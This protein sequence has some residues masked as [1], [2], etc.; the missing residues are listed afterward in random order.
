MVTQKMEAQPK[1]AVIILNYNSK[2]FIL[3]FLDNVVRKSLNADI[4]IFDN[5]S[6]DDSIEYIESKY[7]GLKIIKNKK[8]DGYAGGYNKALKEVCSD[9]YILLNSDIE[10]TDNWINPVIELMKKDNQIAACQPK[11]KNYYNKDYFEYAGASGGFLD[12]LGYPFCRGRIF[13]TVEKDYG[14]YNNSSEI[15]W[16]SGA[17]LFIKSKYFHEVNGFDIDFFAHME[18]ID[19]CWRLKNKGYSIWVEPASTVYHVGG[20]TLNKTNAFK[21]F[22]N[23]RNNLFMMFKN[24]KNPWKIIIIRLFLDGLAGLKFLVEGKPKHTLAIIKAH[25][26][27]YSNIKKLNNKKL[28]NFSNIK[29]FNKSVIISYYLKRIKKFSA[30]K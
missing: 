8:N 25:F 9:Y 21:T 12:Y 24:L 13:N 1:I 28:K 5:G 7:P 6:T 22:L 16:A 11:I 18:E 20:G 2:K 10:V 4:Y 3:K 27:F 15:F 19:L 26:S 14:Q 23:F 17:C 29:L 30:F